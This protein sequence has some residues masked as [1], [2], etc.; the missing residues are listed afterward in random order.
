MQPPTNSSNCIEERL[1]QSE[2]LLRIAGR[3]ARI[4]GWAVELPVDRVVWSDEV[5]AIHEVPV[6]TQPTIEE[7]IGFYALEY[8]EKIRKLF[9]ACVQE[10]I[11]FDVELEI[12]TAK[13]NRVWVRAIGEAETDASGTIR[14]VQGAFQ[15]R[16]DSKVVVVERSHRIAEQLT[17]ILEGITDAFFRVDCEWR[18]TYVNHEAERLMQRSREQLL[19]RVI[20]EVFKEAVGSRFYEEYHRAMREGCTVALEEF[21]AP[22]AVWI[23]AKAYPSAEGL[24]VYFRDI[25]ERKKLEQQ[26]LRAQRME[27]IGTLAGGIAHDLNNVLA[28]ILM[29]IEVLKLDEQ[30][31]ARRD[32]LATI[33]LSARRGAEM[34]KQVLAFAR[35][36]EGRRVGLNINGLLQDVE[37]MANETFLKS[38]QVRT[39]T[40]PELWTVSGD[41]TQIHQV[42]L[43]LCVNARDAMPEGGR[44]TLS[45]ENVTLDESNYL[46]GGGEGRPGPYV[47][48]QVEDTGTGIAPEIL[49]KIFDPFFTTKEVGH[50]TGLG[51]STCLVIVKSHG[52]FIQVD[53]ERGRGSRFKVYLPAEMKV[54]A[55]GEPD[56]MAELPR[57]NGE[58]ILVVDDESAVREITR[59]TLEAFGYR[60]VL[61]SDGTEAV[62]IYA[63]KK[64]EIAVVLTDLMMPVMDGPTTVQVLR[65]LNPRIRVITAS[66]LNANRHIEKL[67][68]AETRH[69]LLKPYTAET[70]LKKVK[71]VLLE[72]V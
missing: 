63:K 48:I 57:G 39:A 64:A 26:L 29:S 32:V 34:V 47:L 12:I 65:K 67:A 28:P 2:S 27:S 31:D 60:V 62:G 55:K 41:P 24:T 58:L 71:E 46:L 15:D 72:P 43:N 8:R 22:S 11:P 9:T 25:T 14:R 69:F 51:L 10:G 59:Q 70:L 5:C 37:K 33:E 21:Y 40:S 45:A 36:V 13:G 18:F 17:N 30:D 54:A 68:N 44:L 49:E 16:T 23:E 4:G 35:G 50:G 53:S 6:G 56:E 20:W 38:I 42:L 66:G 7:A 52:G 1:K 3:L 19:G 61:A